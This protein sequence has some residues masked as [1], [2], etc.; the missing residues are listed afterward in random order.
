MRDPRDSSWLDKTMD[1]FYELLVNQ[2]TSNGVRPDIEA[3][4]PFMDFTRAKLLES[5]KNGVAAGQRRRPTG[6]RPP[7]REA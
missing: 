5:Y 2:F 3:E 4:L 1:E 7:S 6:Q